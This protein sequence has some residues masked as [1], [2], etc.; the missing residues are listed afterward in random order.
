MGPKQLNEEE[1]NAFTDEQE[2]FNEVE[3]ETFVLYSSFCK[4]SCTNFVP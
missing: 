1:T 4:Y 2:L 3:I